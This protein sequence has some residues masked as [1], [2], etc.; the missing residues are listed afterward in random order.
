MGSASRRLLL[1]LAAAAGCAAE[2]GLPAPAPA[3]IEPASGFSTGELPVTI[4]GEAFYVRA[5]QDVEGAE[6]DSVSGA[7]RAWLGEIE[8]VDVARVDAW[9]LAATVPAGV[10]PG[11]YA[12]V[13]EGPYGRS[14]P[15]AGAYTAVPG[16]APVIRLSLRADPPSVP[17]GAMAQLLASVVNLGPDALTQVKLQLRTVVDGHARTPVADGPPLEDLAVGEGFEWSYAVPTT[18]PGTL[19]F[20]AR[21]SAI[22]AVNGTGVPGPKVRVSVEVL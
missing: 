15:L 20:E 9:T 10:V 17:A 8:L 13:V 11:T 6:G 21:V 16:P 3:A 2:Q 14:A 4:V 5:S 19:V 22:D 12:L 18:A 1:V 7:F